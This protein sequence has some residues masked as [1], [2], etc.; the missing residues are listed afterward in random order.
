MILFFVFCQIIFLTAL[1]QYLTL[2][3]YVKFG[4]SG[5]GRVKMPLS[6]VASAQKR[7]FS[8]PHDFSGGFELAES[9]LYLS[10]SSVAHSYSSGSLGQMQFDS[11]SMGSF[12]SPHRSQMHLQS[13]RSQSRED[14]SSSLAEAHLAKT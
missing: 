9:S 2:V 3:N 1:F 12:W 4:D 14:L 7:P 11:S 6:P 5:D 8:T 10:S 13:R